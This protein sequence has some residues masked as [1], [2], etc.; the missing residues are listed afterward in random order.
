MTVGNSTEGSSGPTR[1]V[2]LSSAPYP[3]RVPN[4]HAFHVVG[5][6]HQQTPL[7]IRE[8]FAPSPIQIAELLE[9][10]RDLGHGA[11]L[12][13]TCNRVELYWSGH[14][15]AE[16]AFRALAAVPSRAG[17]VVLIRHSGVDAARHLVRV[18]SGLESQIV[19]E[20]EIL[21]QVRRAYE[22]ARSL[23]TTDRVLDHVFA[24]ALA[25]GRRVRVETGLGSHPVSVS[26]AAVDVIRSASGGSL[27][28]LR[29]LVL[30]AGEMAE[31]VLQA[32]G[33]SDASR[34]TLI[35]R[36]TARALRLAACAG[37]IAGTV[38][39]RDWAALG[40]ALGEADVMFVAT[41]AA[42]PVVTVRSLEARL[43]ARPGRPL[44]IADLG[45]PRNVE[46]DA[47]ALPGVQ[48]Y[49]LDD[50]RALRCPVP[51]GTGIFADA[52]RVIARELDRLE[53]SLAARA[54]AP[55]LAALHRFGEQVVAEE[56]ARALQ[57]LGPL[58][59][60][61]Q[62][63]VREMAERLVRRLLY[64]VSRSLRTAPSEGALTESPLG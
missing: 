34:V 32:L 24:A 47:G 40:A 13:A 51:Y 15:N 26:A 64:P 41:G 17:D 18:A 16:P 60:A 62:A 23:S 30:G 7:A 21:G 46:P 37:V 14:G 8:A 4:L 36:D 44:R 29:V 31:G 10:Q 42:E 22:I 19:G 59:A 35:N 38:T 52:E 25:A 39:V 48:L 56:T 63:E 50:L 2:A 28:G 49:E 1:I 3:W 6:S 57:R 45:V 43:T 20:R 5:I 54:A 9:G 11:V 55:E 61:E 53:A 27:A 33:R 58:G 12:L